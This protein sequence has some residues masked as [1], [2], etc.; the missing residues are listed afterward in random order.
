[1]AQQIQI[2]DCFSSA[3]WVA[4]GNSCLAIHIFR[5]ED[6]CRDPYGETRRIFRFLRGETGDD[7]RENGS[8]N[9]NQPYPGPSSG[10]RLSINSTS[11]LSDNYTMQDTS[12]N[13]P[14]GVSNFLK[15]HTH[16]NFLTR[17]TPWN[18]VRDSASVYQKWRKQIT[19]EDLFNIQESCRKVIQILNHR[20]FW[21]IR[22][23]RNLSVSLFYN[24]HNNKMQNNE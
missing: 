16:V 18:T 11:H 10:A 2:S 1:M 7:R 5:Y 21:N 12:S 15:Y 13:I 3:S 19:Q 22:D 6:L 9:A 4:G 8:R 24:Q 14:E 23:V 17:I 20:F